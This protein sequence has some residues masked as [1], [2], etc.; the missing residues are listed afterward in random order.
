MEGVP[1]YSKIEALKKVQTFL[2]LSFFIFLAQIFKLLS[3]FSL[4]TLSI[5]GA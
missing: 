3:A 5:L 1:V 2:E 4:R